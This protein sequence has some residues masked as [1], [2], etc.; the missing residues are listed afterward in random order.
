VARVRGHYR[1]CR[2]R[3]VSRATDYQIQASHCESDTG[4]MG[5]STAHD[6]P[7]RKWLLAVNAPGIT[8]L[9]TILIMWRRAALERV[10]VVIFATWTAVCVLFLFRHAACAFLDGG[11]G[12]CGVFVIVAFVSIEGV[13][14]F[15][16]PYGI[17]AGAAVHFNR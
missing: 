17:V 6:A 3:A 16:A 15:L 2:Q 8:A 1:G 5:A 9:A 7:V 12:V 10:S 4:R 13:P 11:G 14:A